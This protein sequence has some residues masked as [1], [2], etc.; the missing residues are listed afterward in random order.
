MR[1]DADQGHRS[2]GFTFHRRESRLSYANDD[3]S[4]K[5]GQARRKHIDSFVPE[6]TEKNERQLSERHFSIF[7]LIISGKCRWKSLW[8]VGRCKEIKCS[9]PSPMSLSR[10]TN[11]D[12][13]KRTNGEILI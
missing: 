1:I 10:S 9:S 6:H 3:F 13:K 5:P 8:F 7:L 4:D 12:A 11:A 2:V